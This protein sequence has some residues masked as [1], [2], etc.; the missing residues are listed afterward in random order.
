MEKTTK[1]FKKRNAILECLQHTT[2][3]PSAEMVHEM[4]HD[5]H[6]DIS[7]VPVDRSQRDVRMFVMQHLMYHLR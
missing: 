4:L 5:E 6:P 1:Q 7:Q 3:H 2:S